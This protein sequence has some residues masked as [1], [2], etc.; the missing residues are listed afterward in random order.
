MKHKDIADLG[1]YGL[2]EY[3]TQN[4]KL[5]NESSVYGTGNDAIVTTCEPN[6]ETVIANALLLEGINFDLMYVPLKHL[7]YKAAIT[8]FA[9]VY[10]MNT[11][12][13]QCMINLGISKRLTLQHIEELFSGFVMATETYGVDIVD[14]DVSASYTGLSIAVTAVGQENKDKI[15]TRS[16]AKDTDLICVSGDLG[17]AYMGLQLL[18][19]E[20]S[21]YASQTGGK[22][23][24]FE[25]QPEFAGKEYLLERQLKPEARKDIVSLLSNDHLLPTAMTNV[26]DGLATGLIHICKQSKVGCRV[27]EDRIPIDYQTAA[28]AEEFNMNV[29]TVALNGGDD[30]EL[31]FTVPL[32]KYDIVSGIKGIQ[33]IGHITNE[34]Y[35]IL[36]ETRD[37][38]ELDIKAQGW[39]E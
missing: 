13:K 18:E 1:K 2:I 6:S 23:T 14:L 4:I 25:F 30:N 35:G 3:L 31:L 8:A 33:V 19:R 27:L 36:L 26:S 21:I 37:G 38:A 5:K 22:D 10:A 39:K 29:T 16:N 15:V 34:K 32:S 7:G 11:L 20:K 24:K 28:M 17:A 9:K 12:P